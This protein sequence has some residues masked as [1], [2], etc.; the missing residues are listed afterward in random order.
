MRKLGPGNPGLEEG[1]GLFAT[2]VI[3][4]ATFFTDFFSEGL[5]TGFKKLVNTGC[6]W[7]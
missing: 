3:H 1:Q 7:F 4:R 2:L 6:N 5:E